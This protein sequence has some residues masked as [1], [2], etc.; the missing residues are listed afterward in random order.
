M[1]SLH[2]C[3]FSIETLTIKV[4]ITSA[5][6]EVLIFFFFFFKENSL[7]ISVCQA[8]D[9]HEISRLLFFEKKN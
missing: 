1:S 7:D 4:P 5:A 9:S 6:D 8:D 2:R 3:L